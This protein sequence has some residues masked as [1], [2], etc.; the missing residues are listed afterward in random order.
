MRTKDVPR[1]GALGKARPRLSYA[2]V[3]S[4]LALFAAVGG[5]SYA[6]TQ[7]SGSS[8]RNR[9]IPGNKLVLH[10]VTAK[11]INPAK[12]V[13][14]QALSVKNVFVTKHHGVHR[15][16]DNPHATAD[17]GSSI[18]LLNYGQSATVLTDG[19]YTFTATC[20]QRSDPEGPTPTLAIT[21]QTTVPDTF[22]VQG[23]QTIQPGQSATIVAGSPPDWMTLPGI[24]KTGPWAFGGGTTLV[25]APTGPTVNVAVSAYG[26][27]YAGANCFASMYGIGQ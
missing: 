13:V 21:M 2:N 6:A 8:I 4:T 1:D 15:A 19:D 5:S 12:L 25:T 22:V 18:L 9:S 24:S 16:A 20:D 23:S 27:D 26:F 3:V 11:E 10:G 17:S 14:P 7:I